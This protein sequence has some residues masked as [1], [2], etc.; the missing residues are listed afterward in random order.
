[1]RL[2][3]RK[4]NGHPPITVVDPKPERKPW[5]VFRGVILR[6]WCADEL[7]QVQGGNHD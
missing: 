5:V 2:L 7:E 6:E 3:K 1:M 4:P